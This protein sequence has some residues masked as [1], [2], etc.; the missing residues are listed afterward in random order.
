MKMLRSLLEIEISLLSK[1]NY[2]SFLCYL[3]RTL[4]LRLRLKLSERDETV[5]DLDFPELHIE[6]QR[7][8][9][10]NQCCLNR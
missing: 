10:L 5:S 3:N 7:L 9:L 4:I 8:S 6:T 1:Y 2:S